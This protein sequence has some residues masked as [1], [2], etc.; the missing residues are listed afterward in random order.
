MIHRFLKRLLQ[1][2]KIASLI[3]DHVIDE[4]DFSMHHIICQVKFDRA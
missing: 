3:G 2:L 4:L 1:F